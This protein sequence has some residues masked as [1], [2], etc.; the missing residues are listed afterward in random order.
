[1]HV[2]LVEFICLVFTRMPGQSYRSDSGLC[3]CV[4]VTASLLSV[5]VLTWLTGRKTPSYLLTYWPVWHEFDRPINR[6]KLGD[7]ERKK[8]RK[9]GRN[10]ASKKGRNL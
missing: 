8:D 5:S 7:T 9:E 6:Q 1:M 4:C 2:P 3:G 10:K